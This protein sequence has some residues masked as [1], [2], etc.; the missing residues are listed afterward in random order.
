MVFVPDLFFVF[1]KKTYLN[2]GLTNDEE[3]TEKCGLLSHFKN[4]YIESWCYKQAHIA[5]IKTIAPVI[6]KI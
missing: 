6:I 1:R 4:E 2:D 3:I 5:C